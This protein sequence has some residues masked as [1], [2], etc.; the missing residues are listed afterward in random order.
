MTD[1]RTHMNWML[2]ELEAMRH[3]VADGAAAEKEPVSR[4][5]FA[6]QEGAFSDIRGKVSSMWFDVELELRGKTYGDADE[7]VELI[8]AERLSRWLRGH[9]A[10]AA[11]VA[12]DGAKIDP[13]RVKAKADQLQTYLAGHRLYA[14]RHHAMVAGYC[15]RVATALEHR[16]DELRKAM[17]YSNVG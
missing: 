13:S 12:E 7:D 5:A 8:F 11:G 15:N 9:A 10:Y 4:R 14:I 3:A 2:P 1:R 6:Y 16:A 17:S